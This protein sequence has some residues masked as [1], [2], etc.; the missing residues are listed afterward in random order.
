MLINEV[1]EQSCIVPSNGIDDPSN[2]TDEHPSHGTDENPFL[3]LINS[4]YVYNDIYSI[5]KFDLNQLEQDVVKFFIAGKPL[6]V[7]DGNFR[8]VFRFKN[9]IPGSK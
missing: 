8:T 9:L 1:T 5:A 7:F 6:I 2:V 3:K 4:H